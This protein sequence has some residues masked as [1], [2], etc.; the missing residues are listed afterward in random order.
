[1]AMARGRGEEARRALLSAQ[2]MDPEDPVTWALLGQVFLS[3]G[4]APRAESLLKEARRRFPESLE[5]GRVLAEVLLAGDPTD[6]PTLRVLS[7]LLTPVAN[8]RPQDLAAR[9]KLA[10]VE[11]RLGHFKAAEVLL[12]A[13]TGEEK[14]IAGDWADLGAALAQQDEWKEAVAALLRATTLDP[15]NENAFLNLGNACLAFAVI[16]PRQTEP[17]N[18]AE[19]AYQRARKI[20]PK[21]AMALVGLGRVQI[22]RNPGS[23]ANALATF[24]I[25]E[26]AI[27]IDPKCFEAHHQL[28]LLYYDVWM[29]GSKE[30]TEGFFRARRAC[31]A[32]AAL[33]PPETWSAPAQ[34]AYK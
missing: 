21:N 9:R 18:Q 19:A 25:F 28:A 4:H 31:E 29:A 33:R 6:E 23:N 8:R 17:L 15:N 34:R 5:V 1:L 24:E 14:A 26:E 22:R 32:A 3:T 12:R 7:D 13:L 30:T 16:T 11:I 27:R 2:Q 10:V 20:N